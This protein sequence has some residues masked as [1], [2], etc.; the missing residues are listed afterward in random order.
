[1]ILLAVL[2]KFDNF[3]NPTCSMKLTVHETN[4]L[5][6]RKKYFE[7]THFFAMLFKQNFYLCA[8]KII[9]LLIASGSR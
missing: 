4:S 1:M 8:K 6:Y 7:F 3:L 5:L 2:T 9:L